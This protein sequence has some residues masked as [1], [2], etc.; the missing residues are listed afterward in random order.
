[1]WVYS[2]V[3]VCLG[4]VTRVGTIG[5]YVCLKVSVFCSWPGFWRV[6]SGFFQVKIWRRSYDVLPPPVDKKS[7][8]HPA[9]DP[10]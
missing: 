10:M 8:F 2:S 3:R 6:F 5:V 4:D 9:N 7:E 1:M